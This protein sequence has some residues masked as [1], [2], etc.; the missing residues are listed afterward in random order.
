M[1]FT[2]RRYFVNDLNIYV[3]N[4]VLYFD[5]IYF[6]QNGIK[7]IQDCKTRGI[8][9]LCI[10]IIL[11]INLVQTEHLSVLPSLAFNRYYKPYCIQ[12]EL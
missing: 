12:W 1:G 8:N 10:R 5:S 2:I 4:N 11:Y 7:F 3:K 9:L 6:Y